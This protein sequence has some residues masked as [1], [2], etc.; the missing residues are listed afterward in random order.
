[1]NSINTINSSNGS[2]DED[3]PSIYNR[4]TEQSNQRIILNAPEDSIV[5]INKIDDEERETQPLLD[6]YTVKPSPAGFLLCT[7]LPARYALALWAF[8]GFF[9]LYAMRVNLSVAIVAMVSKLNI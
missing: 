4:S 1:M 3:Q 9:C 5:G 7:N 2:E 8:M 6:E